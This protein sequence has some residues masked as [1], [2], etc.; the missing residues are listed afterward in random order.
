MSQQTRA[1]KTFSRYILYPC[2]GIKVTLVGC[3]IIFD[4]SGGVLLKMSGFAMR[5]RRWM[6]RAAWHG[7]GQV[8]FC[9]HLIIRIHCVSYAFNMHKEHSIFFNFVSQIIKISEFYLVYA[10][11]LCYAFTND[12]VWLSS[13]CDSNVCGHCIRKR[14]RDPQEYLRTW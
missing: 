8:A 2:M 3:R 7:C 10:Y 11:P 9:S 12:Q 5:R 6:A 1:L 14:W 13:Q 4:S